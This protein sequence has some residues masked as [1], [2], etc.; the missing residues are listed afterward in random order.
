MV[1]DEAA[2][3]R[4]VAYGDCKGSQMRRV[5][6]RCEEVEHSARGVTGARARDG[7]RDDRRVRV[8]RACEH[9]G[10]AGEYSLTARPE[11]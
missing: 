2:D 7:G 1:E 5:G 9:R 3:P 4:T 10:A 11:S 6:C 8:S